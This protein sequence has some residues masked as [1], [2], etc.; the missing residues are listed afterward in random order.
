MSSEAMES[1]T[2]ER[3][4]KASPSGNG[5]CAMSATSNCDADE[6]RDDSESAYIECDSEHH[7][8]S[9]VKASWS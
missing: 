4:L 3:F 8:Y 2:T 6:L 1:I 7:N 9:L 5:D